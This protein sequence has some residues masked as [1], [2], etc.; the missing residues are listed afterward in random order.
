MKKFTL[1]IYALLFATIFYGQKFEGTITYTLDYELPE[2]MEAQR[3]MLPTNMITHCKKE[4]SRVEQKTAMGEQI[5]I[6]NNENGAST[7]LMN[8]MGQKMAIEVSQA[9][10]KPKSSSNPVITYYEETKKIA[11]YDCKKASYTVYVEEQKDSVSIDLFYTP[12]IPV[13]YNS[14]FEN[15]KGLPLEYS[16]NTQ[17][18]TMEFVANK[19]DVKKLSKTLFEVPKD[20]EKITL[21]EFKSMM[22][23]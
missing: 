18:M 1:S 10:Q 22:G 9:D 19:V 21:E 5:V 12:E 4:Y 7:L 3:S 6:T 17:G 8:M 14:Q 11:G 23:Q 15:L 13:I 20:Y 2:M 16:L